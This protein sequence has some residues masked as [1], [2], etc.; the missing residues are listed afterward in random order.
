MPSSI[1]RCAFR[2]LKTDP[3]EGA[4]NMAVDEVLLRRT[5]ER[6][7][8]AG[9]TLRFYQWTPPCLSLGR[10]QWVGRGTEGVPEPLARLR[11]L[12]RE[13]G[14]GLVRRPTGGRAIL[15]HRELT[16]SIVMPDTGSDVVESYK[17]LSEGLRLGL[18]RLG[19]EAEF[20]RARGAALASRENCFSI[21]ARADLLVAGTKVVG[22]AQM[23]TSQALLQHGSLPLERDREL[24]ALLYGADD[25]G[26]ALPA[27]SHLARRSVSSTELEAAL[28]AGFEEAWGVPWEEIPLTPDEASAAN[29]LAA[30]KY[31]SDTWT[32]RGE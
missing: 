10:H 3:A 14:L 15:H 1:P 28:L 13:L 24:E 20:G 9:T 4:W 21:S 6:P 26:H 12:C 23:R 17:A 5:H 19:L 16:Y 18:R 32:M 25:P 31:A 27:I 2:L 7:E 8:A 29:R 11:S 30:T 22:S